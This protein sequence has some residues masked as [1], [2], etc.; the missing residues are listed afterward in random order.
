MKKNSYKFSFVRMATDE[1]MAII[2]YQA[3]RKKEL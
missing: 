2:N 3:K 1:I